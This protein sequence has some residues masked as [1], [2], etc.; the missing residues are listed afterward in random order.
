MGT[1]TTPR[2][3]RPAL[4][5]EC[6]EARDVPAGNVTALVSG[7]ALLL[8]GDSAANQ[9]RVVQN[10]FGN[11]FV[12]G[13]TGTTVNGRASVFVGR[14]IPAALIADLG[15]GDDRIEVSGLVSG[16][17]AIDGGLGNDVIT[18][19]NRRAAGNVEV[20]GGEGADTVSLSRVLAGSI[21]IVGGLGDDASTLSN[22]SAA[23]YVGFVVG[24]GPDI[25]PGYRLPG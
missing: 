7:G 3:A 6:L 15:D 18:L 17:I 5:I 11:V 4:G 9:V 14:G 25:V 1:A 22:S 20:F 8:T 23:V 21:V 12:S 13:L 2:N 19:S 16:G 24:V 10:V